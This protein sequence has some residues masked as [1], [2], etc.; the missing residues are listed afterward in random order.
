MKRDSF[1]VKRLNESYMLHAKVTK[2][3]TTK[4]SDGKMVKHIV[5]AF[6]LRKNHTPV[7][8]LKLEKIVQCMH[9]LDHPDAPQF[10][11]N[12][13]CVFIRS[14]P[15]GPGSIN[16]KKL[17]GGSYAMMQMFVLHE[18]NQLKGTIDEQVSS[19]IDDLIQFLTCQHFIEEYLDLLKAAGMHKMLECINASKAYHI[20]S[21]QKTTVN[22]TRN[23]SL[24]SFLIDA[25]MKG[26]YCKLH[27]EDGIMYPKMVDDKELDFYF[28]KG[29]IKNFDFGAH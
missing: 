19:I 8:W 1:T 9:S 20:E 25:D 22:I 5:I 11:K 15:A 16:Q 27:P 4:N 13:L 29:E 18:L 6:E 12:M 23:L 14:S 10:F 2:H 17:Q 7:Y 21:L 26:I 28:E 3:C 24:N